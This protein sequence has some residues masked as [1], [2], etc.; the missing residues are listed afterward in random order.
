MKGSCDYIRS[1]WAMVSDRDISEALAPYGVAAVPDLCERI[2]GYIALLLRWNERI[3]LTTITKPAEVLQLHFGES[4]FA[5]SALPIRN[6]RLADVG[7]GAGFP[8]IPLA[9]IAPD[10]EVN[11]IESNLKKSTFLS[12]V[13]R[14]LR[15]A[16]V[17]VVRS[18]IEDLP[19]DLGKFDFITARAVGGHESL[20]SWASNSLTQSGR[21]VL[22]LGVADADELSRNPSWIWLTPIQIR[23]SRRRVLLIGRAHTSK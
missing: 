12:E 20:L 22:W 2:R 6:G 19:S 17:R 9:M 14:A 15:L 4:F 5:A 11:L 13:V 23:G 1:I 10:L 8:G 21:V 3:S 7:S 16:N 18:R